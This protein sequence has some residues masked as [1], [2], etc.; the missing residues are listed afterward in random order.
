[1]PSYNGLMIQPLESWWSGG[2]A[3]AH[4]RTRPLETIK[5]ISD[6][7]AVAQLPK[8]A[9]NNFRQISSLVN[10]VRLS[11]RSCPCCSAFL[12]LPTYL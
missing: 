8:N 6:T 9:T 11:A 7:E 2:L 10:R 5:R 4:K 1:V 12:I 3:E